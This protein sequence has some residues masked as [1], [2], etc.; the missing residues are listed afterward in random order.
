VIAR[1]KAKNKPLI[2]PLAAPM[3]RNN[4]DGRDISG[5]KSEREG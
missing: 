5:K 1:K 4:D 3:S 2:I